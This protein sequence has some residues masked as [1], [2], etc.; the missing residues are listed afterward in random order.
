MK[1]LVVGDEGVG[2]RSFTQELESSS[3][4]NYQSH[5][6][7][8]KLTL[9]NFEDREIRCQLW[10]IN[11]DD[12]FQHERRLFYIGSLAAIIIF[13]VN[14]NKTF[15][16]VEKW[17]LDIWA[18]AGNDIP[19]VLLGNNNLDSIGSIEIKIKV[20]FFIKQL[21]IKEK[22][23]IIAIKYI[24]NQADEKKGFEEALAYLSLQY[25]YNF[26]R[27]RKHPLNPKNNYF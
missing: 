25:F 10:V 6:F 27:K 23:G 12:R 22:E 19:I 14:R 7:E 15:E 9:R 21:M 1:I 16:S 11:P 24:E 17:I 2:K 4:S 26:E 5:G 8:S 3:K 20:N 18:G 13:D